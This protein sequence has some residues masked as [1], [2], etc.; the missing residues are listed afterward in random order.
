MKLI[1]EILRAGEPANESVLSRSGLLILKTYAS[2]WNER[3]LK[4]NLGNQASGFSGD[5]VVQCPFG[6]L[7][8]RS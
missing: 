5:P 8:G 6:T 4:H 1:D 3:I 2:W 7:L